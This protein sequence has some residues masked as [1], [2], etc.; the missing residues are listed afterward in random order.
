MTLRVRVRASARSRG[1]AR[2]KASEELLEATALVVSYVGYSHC[3]CG[4]IRGL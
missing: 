4:V 2:A 1:R 3:P